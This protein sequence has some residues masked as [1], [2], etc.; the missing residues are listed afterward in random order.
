MPTKRILIDTNFWLSTKLLR[1]P[2][3]IATTHLVRTSG[4][5]LLLPEVI[6]REIEAN[7]NAEL[8]MLIKDH[9]VSRTAIEDLL[10]ITMEQRSIDALDL[11]RALKVR[12]VELEQLLERSPFTF[13]D[14]KSALEKCIRKLPPCT[15]SQQFKDA[16]IWSSALRSAATAPTI[17]VTHD[18][19]FFD[20]ST[21][22][23]LA[24]TLAAEASGCRFPLTAHFELRDLLSGFQPQPIQDSDGRIRTAIINA[25]MEFL[26]RTIDPSEPVR[27]LEP[28][29]DAAIR[30]YLTDVPDLYAIDF[31]LKV[32]ALSFLE[33][34]PRKIV[35]D[36]TGSCTWSTTTNTPFDVD[37][38][39]HDILDDRGEVEATVVWPPSAS[40]AGY[41]R[42]YTRGS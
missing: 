23:A 41:T 27:L 10:G 39:L 34:S 7:A 25:A 14:A 36:Y 2:L 13:D 17:L 29:P 11:E 8:S 38:H 12:F 6:E 42:R 20:E 32:D 5:K 1:G 35:F 28:K 26:I 9:E 18:K 16:A 30:I 4:W 21:N 24:A 3:G 15:R 37:I 22:S 33:P 31:S 19:A 40:S